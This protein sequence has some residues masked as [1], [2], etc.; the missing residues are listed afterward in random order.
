MSGPGSDPVELGPVELGPV[1]FD[2]RDCGRHV[3]AFGGPA[4]L[5]L[6]AACQAMPGWW[7][8]PRLRCA[9]E[10]DPGWVPP[11]DHR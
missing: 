9:F 8:D 10:P 4:G 1:E 6:C 5:S 11:A 2:C 7:K 3:I